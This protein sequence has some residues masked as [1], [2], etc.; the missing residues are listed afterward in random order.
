MF[1]TEG[2][3]KTKRFYKDDFKEGWVGCE[4]KTKGFIKPRAKLYKVKVLGRI[5]GRCVRYGRIGG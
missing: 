1:L 2:L 5:G 3:I 4:V